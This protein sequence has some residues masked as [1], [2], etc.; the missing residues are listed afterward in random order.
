MKSVKPVNLILLC[1]WLLQMLIEGLTLL[2]VW[3][4]DMLP[5]KYFVLL[6]AVFF[7]LVLLS[8]GL[9]FW[10]KAGDK[11]M[12]VRRWIAC[13]F[14]VL[15]AA[16]CAVTSG[17]ITQLRHTIHNVTTQKPAGVMMSVYIR[18]DDPAQTLQD[19][20]E[21]RFASVQGYEVSK[22]EQVLD[23]I[24]QTLGRE[25]CTNQYKSVFAMIDALLTGEAD[26]IIL[27]SAYV[28]LLEDVE[29]YSDFALKTRVLCEVPVT[30]E[31]DPVPP[32]EDS[33]PSGDVTVPTDPPVDRTVTSAP[34]VLYISGSDTRS[35]QLRTSLSDVNILVVVNPIAKQILLLNTPR[36]YYVPNPA[37]D[38]ALD[39]LTHCGLYGINCS[40]QALSNLY[41][42]SVDY[43]AQINFTG[44]KTLID[45]I[46]G[47]VVHSNA[48]F[49]AD[50]F[51]FQEGENLLDG[52]KALAFA[53]ERH[54]VAGGDNGR[55][56]NQMRLITAVIDKLASSTALIT[57]YSAI[58]QSLQGMFVT[59]M[60]ASDISQFMKM[61]L[62]DMATWDVRSYAV[63]GKNS[64]DETYTM[65]GLEVSV[66]Y[67]DQALVDHGSSLIKRMLAGEVLSGSDL[68]PT[69]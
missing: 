9:L 34:F 57:N 6:A 15:I 1:I 8:G 40:V 46:G 5:V 55:G 65:P 28:D 68:K 25:L 26:A 4:L 29:Q 38:G 67:V 42:I 35:E 37:G 51:E 22:S 39:K 50:G 49:T 17:V 30:E 66:M 7:V 48:S 58:M 52:E 13:G 64:R 59:N 43:Y 60:E 44:F 21:Y 41:G 19:A 27:N 31:P 45:A 36:D 2:S 61:Q 56:K 16:G 63:T 47:V 33:N 62:D 11:V 23:H 54:N 12:P 32:A 53:R 18:A 20:A 69:N 10:P 14:I 3:R 24:S